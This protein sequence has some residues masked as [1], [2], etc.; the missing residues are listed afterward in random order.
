MYAK[1]QIIASTEDLQL[2]KH[3]QVVEYSSRKRL[4]LIAA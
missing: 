2:E 4:D 3:G 1:R